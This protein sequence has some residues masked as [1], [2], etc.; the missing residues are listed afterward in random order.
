MKTFVL[1]VNGQTHTLEADAD[2]PLLYVLRNQLQ[3][4]GPKYGCGMQQC[5]ACMVLIN[6][7]AQASC[8][9]PVSSVDTSSITT[10]EGL[11]TKKG[12]MHAVQEA[13][14]IEQ[15]AQC[16]FCLNGM[17]ISAVALL[18]EIPSPDD[19]QIRIALDRSLCR[20]G[21]HARILRAVKRAAKI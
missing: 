11:E 19:E 16:G 20:C 4:N 5:G 7:V 12:K 9:M 15:A 8:M 3:L 18:Q 10:I 17:V 13:F 1:K 2:T 6:G 14:V 21:S